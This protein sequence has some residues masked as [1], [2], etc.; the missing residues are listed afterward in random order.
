MIAFTVP[1]WQQ[2]LPGLLAF[3][4]TVGGGIAFWFIAPR[5]MESS[6]RKFVKLALLALFSGPY[7]WCLCSVIAPYLLFKYR[8]IV[9]SVEV[10]HEEVKTSYGNDRSSDIRRD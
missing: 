8:A 10:L 9:A 6:S 7:V 5:I 2:Y 1:S 3:A 4:W